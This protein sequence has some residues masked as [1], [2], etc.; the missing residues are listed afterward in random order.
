M[1]KACVQFGYSRAF[2]YDNA[3]AMDGFRTFKDLNAMYGS[4]KVE[5]ISFSFRLQNVRRLLRTIEMNED[6]RQSI[7]SVLRKDFSF[8]LFRRNMARILG[9][10]YIPR[11]V[12]TKDANGQDTTI[13][14]DEIDHAMCASLSRQRPYAHVYAFYGGAKKSVMRQ[15]SFFERSRVNMIVIMRKNTVTRMM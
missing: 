8:Y 13:N 14:I 3:M 10:G 6:E 11:E 1:F 9:V 15:Y 5:I 4:E 7:I 2:L 12:T